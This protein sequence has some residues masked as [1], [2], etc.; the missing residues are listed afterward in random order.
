MPASPVRPAVAVTNLRQPNCTTD[1]GTITVASPAGPQY[2]YSKDG[3]AFQTSRIFN[4]VD[5]GTYTITVDNGQCKSTTLVTIDNPPAPAPSPGTITGNDAVCIDDI[6]QLANAAT[7]GTWSSSNTGIATVNANG[8]VT[9]KRSGNVTITYTVGTVCTAAAQKMITVNALPQPVLQDNYY[10]CTDAVTGINS[11]ITLHS[12]L[13]INAYS[14]AWTKDGT[15]LTTTSGYLNTNEP[16]NYEVTATDLITGCSATAAA[17]IKVSSIASATA[18]VGV[19]FNFNQVITITVTGG[20]GD[21]VYSLD[22]GRFQDEPYFTKFDEGEHEILVKDRNN[23]GTLSL[24][25]FSLNYPRF[26][27]PNGD[28]V[29]EVWNIKGL[30][31]QRDAVIYIYDRFG[32]LITGIRPSGTGWDGTLNG[33]LL[34]AT[35]Y[36]FAVVYLSSNGVQKEFKAHFSLLR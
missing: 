16:G 8:L 11:T 33:H 2:T 18:V 14:F 23:C 24:N 29:G 3:T 26:F 6:L 7:G 36:W 10:V 25:V 1:K 20:S 5:P 22:G 35:D 27:S 31:S 32:K 30:Q 4:D 17:T 15:A 21:Y 12:G 13:A 34:P 19:D 28:G 9:P